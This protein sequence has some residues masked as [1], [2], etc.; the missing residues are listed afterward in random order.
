TSARTGPIEHR[1]ETGVR[2][3]YDEIRRLHTEDGF[4]MVSGQLVPT[5]EPLITTADN[6]ERT[7]AVAVHLTDAMAWKGLTITP[8]ARLEIITSRTDDYLTQTNTDALTPAVM[9]GIGAYY[10]L[11]PAVGVLG[12]VYRG[13]SPPAPG[14]SV[15]PEYS[16]N[17]EAGARYTRGRTRAELIGF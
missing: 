4:F 7:D 10:E 5:K 14:A 1:F 3:H 8:G 16:V 6:F 11:T 17:Y 15:K 2:F 12:G 9:P 13:F